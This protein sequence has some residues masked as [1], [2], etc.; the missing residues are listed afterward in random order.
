MTALRH[1]VVPLAI[2]AGGLVSAC[3]GSEQ[4]VAPSNPG[5]DGAAVV[6]VTDP[7]AQT[8]ATVA[9]AA[10][11]A[12]STTVP[13][14][15]TA[16]LPLATEPPAPPP[17]TVPAD[18]CVNP[19]GDLSG[20]PHDGQCFPPD[21][22][23][24]GDFSGHGADDSCGTPPTVAVA[25]APRCRDFGL[26]LGRDRGGY[27]GMAW[28]HD[29][30]RAMQRRLVTLGYGAHINASGGADGQ[31]GTGTQAAL[32][33]WAGDHGWDAA[34]AH[35]YLSGTPGHEWIAGTRASLLPLLGVECRP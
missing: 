2:A 7:P 31:F 3:T 10:E 16:T 29:L 9:P 13:A 5:R 24:D 18:V 20:S 17:S 35:L 28:E 32:D 21:I 22:C 27:N 11:P 25:T 14:V 1:V 34:A 15:G 23:P 6:V 30:I 33:V 8:A 19:D 4:V 26:Y 12:P